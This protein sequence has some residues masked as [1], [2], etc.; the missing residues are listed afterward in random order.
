MN[1]ETLVFV[2]ES[3][4][5]VDGRKFTFTEQKDPI[6]CDSNCIF[7]DLSITEC[8]PCVC[9]DFNR[10]DHKNGIFIYVK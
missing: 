7:K 10:I 8:H 5:M 2:D 4:G 1:L 3:N 6:G 9:N